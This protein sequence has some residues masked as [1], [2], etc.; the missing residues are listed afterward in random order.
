[1]EITLLAIECVVAA[2]LWYGAIKRRWRLMTVCGLCMCVIFAAWVGV[3]IAA[4]DIFSAV[5]EGINL[6]AWAIATTLLLVRS[7]DL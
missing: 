2:L 6:G 4:R 5:F 3:A 1:M 7:L